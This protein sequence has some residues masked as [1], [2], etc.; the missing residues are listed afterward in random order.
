MLTVVYYSI[1][2]YKYAVSRNASSV[3][4]LVI[5]GR[6]SSRFHYLIPDEWTRPAWL[7]VQMAE[8]VKLYHW[9]KHGLTLR[10]NDILYICHIVNKHI[11]DLMNSDTETLLLGAQTNA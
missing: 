6:T 9:V 5:F 1:S 3:S 2:L 10:T 7:S 4:V 11:K 8:L